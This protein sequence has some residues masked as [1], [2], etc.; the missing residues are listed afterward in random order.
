MNASDFEH[1]ATT[2]PR[3]RQRRVSLAAIFSGAVVI[4]FA[5][6]PARGD[7][8]ASDAHRVEVSWSAVSQRVLHLPP[9]FLTGNDVLPVLLLPSTL[10]AAD[11]TC[12]TIGVLG[13]RTIDFSLELRGDELS[14]AKSHAREHGIAQSVAGALTIVRCGASRAEL[15]GLAVRMKSPQGA[16]EIVVARG[17]QPAPTLDVLLPERAAGPSN[18]E[19]VANTPKVAASRAAR[20]A[21]AENWIQQGAG[22]VSNR[23]EL[24]SDREGAGSARLPLAPGCHQLFVVAETQDPTGAM[25]ADVDAELTRLDLRNVVARDRSFAPDAMVEHCLGAPAEVQLRW[26][27]APRSAPTTVM[28]GSWAI[29]ER[30]PKEWEPRARAGLAQALLRRHVPLG[31]DGP[32]WQGTGVT[33][34]TS[35]PL[36]VVPGVCYVFGVGAMQG[37]VRAIRLSVQNGPRIS[38]DSGQLDVGGAAIA[39][40]SESSGVARVDVNAIGSQIAWRAAAWAVASTP[41]GLEESK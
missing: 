40:C 36:Q 10:N 5:T 15:E 4:S 21:D 34:R 3:A 19:V 17:V 9:S 13:T 30:V 16:V 7:E 41:L 12:T 14:E 37:E 25:A 27:G 24:A 29:P 22:R 33:S 32:V 6:S 8:A 1:V 18:P 11:S 35:I 26:V 39:F 38:T 31:T 20:L 2:S 23:M 28:V